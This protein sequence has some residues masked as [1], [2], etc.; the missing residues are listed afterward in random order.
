MNLELNQ[1]EHGLLM[2]LLESRVEELHPEIRHTREREFKDN[3][4]RELDCLVAL[5]QRVKGLAPTAD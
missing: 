1:E 2:A 5:L 4:K 3:L